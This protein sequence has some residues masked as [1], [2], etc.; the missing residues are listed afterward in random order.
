MP[1]PP[2]S[3]GW[4]LDTDLRLSAI[5]GEP[6]TLAASTATKQALTTKNPKLKPLKINRRLG[7]KS[8]KSDT[9]KEKKKADEAKEEQPSTATKPSQ[10]TVKP[11]GPTEPKPSPTQPSPSPTQPTQQQKPPAPGHISPS[12][13]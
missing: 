7:S 9:D 13:R 4:G 11:G 5:E 2:L 10:P 12:K 1:Y 8:E 6:E 3:P